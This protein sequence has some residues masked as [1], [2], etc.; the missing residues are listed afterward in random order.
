MNELPGPPDSPPSLGRRELIR[1]GAIV[2]GLVWSIPLIK[3]VHAVGGVGSEQPVGGGT[4][5]TCNCSDEN[6]RVVLQS[7]TP[8]VENS[9]ACEAFCREFC[10]EQGRFSERVGFAD[11]GSVD[12]TCQPTALPGAEGMACACPEA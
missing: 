3:T 6:G 8:G 12:S 1:D 2:G 10:V 7:C 11:C 9:S 5:C 4:C